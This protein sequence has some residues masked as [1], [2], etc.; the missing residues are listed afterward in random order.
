MAKPGK[1]HAKCNY[2]IYLLKILKTFTS[3]TPFQ[4]GVEG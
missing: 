3:R 2:I 1:F 4:R